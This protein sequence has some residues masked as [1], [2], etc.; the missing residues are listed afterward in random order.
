MLWHQQQ[1]VLVAQSLLLILVEH[2]QVI[3]HLMLELVVLEG[4]QAEPLVALAA[5]VAPVVP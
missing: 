4:P 3:K 2:N 5:L 1:V